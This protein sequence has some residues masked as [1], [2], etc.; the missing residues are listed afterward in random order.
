MAIRRNGKALDLSAW[1][2]IS[3]TFLYLSGVIHLIGQCLIGEVLRYS[4]D[5]DFTCAC[6]TCCV[7][8]TEWVTVREL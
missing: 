6:F 5:D 1:C 3:E 4:Y 7:I 2:L 8:F